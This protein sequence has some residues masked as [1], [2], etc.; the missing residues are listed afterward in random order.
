MEDTLLTSYEL[1]I[2]IGPYGIGQKAI[3]YGK[4]LNIKGCTIFLGK[5]ITKQRKLIEYL[6]L[7]EFRREI[8]LLIIDKNAEDHILVELNR[9]IH[10][11]KKRGIAFT[12]PL[13]QV[14]GSQSHHNE[15]INEGVKNPMHNAIFTVVDK[16]NGEAVIK[17]ARKAGS[18][19]ATIINARGSGI[20][21][22]NK[23]FNMEISPEKEVVLIIDTHS[24]SENIVKHIREDLNIDDRGKGIIFILDINKSFGLFKDTEYKAEQDK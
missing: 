16:G 15:V 12:I 20:H 24:N 23:L 21:E 7:D 22:A 2:V 1:L 17:S 10:F 8:A 13:K 4:K 6:N 14:I 19:G 11:D 5:G 18:Q 3:K 9:K